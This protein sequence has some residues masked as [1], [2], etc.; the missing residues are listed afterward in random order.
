[1][2]E[3]ALNGSVPFLCFSIRIN[4]FRKLNLYSVANNC[5]EGEPISPYRRI[6]LL[7]SCQNYLFSS[8][9]NKIFSRHIGHSARKN[10]HLKI[11]GRNPWLFYFPFIIL[12]NISNIK[13]SLV[14]SREILDLLQS[15]TNINF[16]DFEEAIPDDQQL[17]VPAVLNTLSTITNKKQL[18]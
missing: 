11:L 5:F 14:S 9:Q 1:M 18:I 3:H 15:I 7:K 8:L 13:L 2:S 4:D 6:V 17:R 10:C 12:S 16:F